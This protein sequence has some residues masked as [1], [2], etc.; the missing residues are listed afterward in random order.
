[1]KDESREHNELNRLMIAMVEG[2]IDRDGLKRLEQLLIDDPEA[3]QAYYRYMMVHASLGWRLGGVSHSIEADQASDSGVLLEVIEDQARLNR[4]CDERDAE[5]MAQL[6]AEQAAQAEEMGR[7]LSLRPGSDGGESVRR[8][9]IIPPALVYL[10][11]AA[12]LLIACLVGVQVFKPQQAIQQ[13]S[14]PGPDPEIEVLPPVVAEIYSSVDAQW[15]GHTSGE[16]RLR[17]DTPLTLVDG[18][19]EIEFLDG[20]RVV[21]QAPAVFELTNRNAMRLT[22]GKLV[23]TVPESASGFVVVTANTRI[24]DIGTEFGLSSLHDGKCEAH[25]YRGEITVAPTES[26]LGIAAESVFAG[27]AVAIDDSGLTHATEADELAFVRSEEYNAIHD[28]PTSAAARWLAYTYELRRD[29]A[30]LAFY[31]FDEDTLVNGAA[32]NIADRTLGRFDATLGD[33][34]AMTVPAPG[35]DR[36]GQDGQAL[37]FDRRRGQ[38][39]YVDDWPE[40]RDLDALTISC[41]FRLANNH[42]TW[43]LLVTHWHDEFVHTDRFA[44]HLGLRD[45]RTMPGPRG[46]TMGIN[47]HISHDGSTSA[48]PGWDIKDEP[49]RGGQTTPQDGWVHV[50]LTVECDGGPIRLFKNGVEIDIDGA[51]Y[52]PAHLPRIRHPL[53]IGGKAT[54]HGADLSQLDPVTGFFHGEIDDVAIFRRALSIEEVQAM[55]DAGAAESAAGATPPR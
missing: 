33:G 6:Q 26:A 52:G 34:R 36:F 31:P 16:S 11:I 13:A 25:V 18:F 1:M 41:W 54:L 15:I 27:Q 46:R 55:Y 10:G 45:A 2:V 14:S 9:I 22:S 38:A 23:A 39:L 4:E 43:A 35:D 40:V 3:R 29:P 28:S 48:G 44:Y 49:S 19:A 51:R 17:S 8:I 5:W 24:V 20:A 12:C 30:L 47:A 42:G 32:A 7:R 50:V 53:V 37:T 21:V